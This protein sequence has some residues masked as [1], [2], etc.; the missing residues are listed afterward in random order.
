MVFL[1]IAILPLAS[2]FLFALNASYG[3]NWTLDPME[4]KTT[5]SKFS[6]IME[7]HPFSNKFRLTLKK[8]A[9]FSNV[10]FFYILS[11]ALNA[12]SIVGRCVALHGIYVFTNKCKN[13][14]ECI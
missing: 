12:S 1:F 14:C 5:R 10:N 6:Y 7:C 4:K 11:Q 9:S 2:K 3:Q 8:A 13:Q